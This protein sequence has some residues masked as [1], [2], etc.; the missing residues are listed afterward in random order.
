[1][2]K[3][4][5]RGRAIAI[6]AITAALTGMALAPGAQASTISHTGKVVGDSTAKVKLK[7]KKK[8]NKLRSVARAKITKL[9]LNCRGEDIRKNFVFGS[10][11]ITGR[12]LK[13]KGK[14]S[15]SSSDRNA[16]YSFSGTVK[17]KGKKVV[18]E[19]RV[20]GMFDTGGSRPDRCNA[21]GTFKTSA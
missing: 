6:G 17:K 12:H 2:M 4:R 3:R 20:T 15:I 11:P 5:A 21:N 18:G 7:V 1:M 14:F 16:R 8:N 10:G 19:F 13:R 9:K